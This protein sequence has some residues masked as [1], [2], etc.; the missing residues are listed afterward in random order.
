MA[1]LCMVER[2][3]WAKD[4]VSNRLLVGAFALGKE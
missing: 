4:R 2:M 1:G 3:I